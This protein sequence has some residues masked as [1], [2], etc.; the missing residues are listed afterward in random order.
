MQQEAPGR[1]MT[2]ERRCRASKVLVKHW[3]D[4]TAYIWPGH[5][6]TSATR[7]SSSSATAMEQEPALP[8][9]TSSNAG[10]LCQ[11]GGFSSNLAVAM[12]CLCRSAV[13]H[14]WSADCGALP[15][16]ASASA[17]ALATESLGCKGGALCCGR[18]SRC[19]QRLYAEEEPSPARL[20]T[21]EN[22]RA[23]ARP[24]GA[25]AWLSAGATGGLAV[26]RAAEGAM[27]AMLAG[28]GRWPAWP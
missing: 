23:W 11:A 10:S 7:L 9:M 14:T 24:A 6:R 19:D 26:G 13:H 27:P 28:A 17:G 5:S 2:K 1:A 18:R 15:A 21:E 22:S 12:T 8:L 3:S 20:G 16:A 4:A 25:L